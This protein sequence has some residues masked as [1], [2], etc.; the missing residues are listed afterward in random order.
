MYTYL[1]TNIYM[2]IHYDLCVC[3]Y[4]SI[5]M[6]LCIG[7]DLSMSLCS[8]R[9]YTHVYIGLLKRNVLPDF[10]RP[11]DKTIPRARQ[12]RGRG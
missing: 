11:V 1:R 12:L 6:H 5:G 10:N 4:V 2:R 8:I 9:T 7:L 3:I